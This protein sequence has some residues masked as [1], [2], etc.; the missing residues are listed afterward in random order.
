M[1]G[2]KLQQGVRAE[3][4]QRTG[5]MAESRGPNEDLGAGATGGLPGE[6]ALLPENWEAKGAV[7]HPPTLA[8]MSEDSMILTE[9]WFSRRQNGI[10]LATR[11]HDAVR[12]CENSGCC[13]I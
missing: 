9:T 12:I 6:R 2:E 10:T 8:E 13:S 4:L 3:E 1:K 5:S 11:L 7:S